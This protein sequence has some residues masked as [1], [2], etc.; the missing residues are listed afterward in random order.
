MGLMGDPVDNIPG[1]KGIGEKTAIALVQQFETL[2]NLFQHLDEVEKMNLRGAARVRK[3]LEAGR[4]TAFLSREL[5]TVNADVPLATALEELRARQ[6][7]KEKLR[8]LFGEL[9]F[10]NLLKLLEQG[11][12]PASTPGN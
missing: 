6:A 4:E 2:E 8:L 10:T 12:S 7:D 1:V 5:A 11:N 3:S 9:G